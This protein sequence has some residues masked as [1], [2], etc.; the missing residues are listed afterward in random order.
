MHVKKRNLPFMDGIVIPIS[1]EA[2]FQ[3]WAEHTMKAD[4][5]LNSAGF[6]LPPNL[7]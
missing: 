6:T 3:L 4:S 5:Y 2:H 1:A 7:L